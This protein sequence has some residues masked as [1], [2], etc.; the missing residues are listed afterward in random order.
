MLL[1]Q[2]FNYI[3]RQESKKRGSDNIQFDMLFQYDSSK[4]IPGMEVKIE[5]YADGCQFL[6][7]LTKLNPA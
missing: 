2:K 4:L 5:Y 1:E 7:A 6:A 3:S